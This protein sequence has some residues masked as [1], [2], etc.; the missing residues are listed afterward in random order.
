VS[1]TVTRGFLSEW[2]VHASPGGFSMKRYSTDEP[3]RAE[4]D[5]TGGPLLLEFGSNGCGICMGTQPLLQEAL[6]EHESLPHIRVED[7]RGRPLGRSFRVKL[8][9]TLVFMM[10][11]KEVTR[12]VRPDSATSIREALVL[13][14]GTSRAP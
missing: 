4:I 1:A 3:T 14:D 11:G 7:G 2:I 10:D 8:W 9:P 13:L 6:E 5:A 12:L